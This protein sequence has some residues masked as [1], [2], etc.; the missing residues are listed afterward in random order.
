MSAYQEDSF[1]HLRERTPLSNVSALVG[2][3][4]YEM[5]YRHTMFPCRGDPSWSA[6]VYLYRHSAIVIFGQHSPGVHMQNHVV[7]GTRQPALHLRIILTVTALLITTCTAN[8]IARESPKE[9]G[10]SAPTSV[11]G[12]PTISILNINNF[13]RFQNANGSGNHD[14]VAGAGGRFPRGTATCIYQD[15]FVWGA[16]TFLDASLTQ[17]SYQLVRVGGQTYNQ[18]TREGWVNGW[19]ANA[20]AVPPTDTRSRIYRIRRDY[21]VM[22]DA[23]ARSDAA[24]LLLIS[25]G[26]VTPAQILALRNQ[27]ALDWTSWPV[28]IGAP[29]IERNGSPGY[30]APPPFSTT[31]TP[32][33]LIPGRYDEPG[34]GNDSPADQV[35]WMVYNDLDRSATLALYRSEPLGLE[36]QLTVWG[37]K[38]TDAMS[39]LHFT[40]LRI[41]NKGGVY[42]Q[43]ATSGVKGSYYLDSVYISQW[44]DPDLGDSGD[45]LS[46]CDTSLSLGYCY[47]GNA[48]DV[49]YQQY[50][51]APPGVGYRLLQG[52][53]V[54]SAGDTGVFDFRRF[55]NRRNLRLS[56]FSYFAAG[57]VVSDPPL[58]SSYESTLK[59]WRMLRGF[60][61]DAESI[62]LR[63]YPFPPGY[64]AG[65]FVFT[66]NPTTSQGFRDG[67]G[68]DYSPASGDRRNIMSVGPFRMAPG[69]TQEVV[70]T[71]IG[72]LGGD[73]LSSISVMNFNARFARN[74]FDAM[75]NPQVG[76]WNPPSEVAG[77]F[78]LDQNFPNPLNPSTIIVYSLPAAGDVTLRVFDVL[79][80]EVTTLVQ[81]SK[82]A[83]KHTIEWNAQGLSSGVYFYRLE[84][85]NHV[86]TRKMVV[87][88]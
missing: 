16:K 15:G 22:S 64:T 84:A 60:R 42:L 36:G 77:T 59:W 14:I 47:N 13:T 53:M 43:S 26:N 48:V 88:K 73:R 9:P 30:Q 28:D 11:L 69:D 68:M 71:L 44:S 61:P 72:G 76:V 19:G 55:L 37:Y 34:V 81:G 38:R 6:F 23:E 56:S 70:T 4:S 29:Y 2:A 49:E 62:T 10:G 86:A 57:G 52:P 7:A 32:D 39:N 41:I 79:G 50:S 24:T 78:E 66:G 65:P 40:R 20:V 87:L 80:R 5:S 74:S 8:A 33:S 17:S 3:H 54:Y 75:I 18:G 67:L 46:G 85:G 12:T 25:E 82:Q 31:F 51:I 63:Y 1:L 27:Y 21:F 35:L 58:N 45:D 83:G